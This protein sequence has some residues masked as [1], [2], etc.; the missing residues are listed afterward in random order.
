MLCKKLLISCVVS[1]LILGANEADKEYQVN[2]TNGAGGS[3]KKPSFSPNFTEGNN[4]TWNQSDGSLVI[5]PF[6]HQ[7]YVSPSVIAPIVTATFTSD[8]DNYGILTLKTFSFTNAPFG[9]EKP[10]D[11]TKDD[12]EKNQLTSS[13]LI[14]KN[15]ATGFKGFVLGGSGASGGDVNLFSGAH[16][17]IEGFTQTTLQGTIN[18]SAGGISKSQSS[19]G[20]L[21]SSLSVN[22]DKD[23]ST[24]AIK[25]TLNLITDNG[26]DRTKERAQA[27]FDAKVKGNISVEGYVSVANQAKIG[28]EAGNALKIS[29]TLSIS[30]QEMRKITRDSLGNESVLDADRM[31]QT[32]LT[33]YAP[34]IELNGGIDVG[35]NAKSIETREKK[36]ENGTKITE[37]TQ[38]P[39]DIGA[40]AEITADIKA[41]QTSSGTKPQDWEE[42]TKAQ[43]LQTSGGR[44]SIGKNSEVRIKTI[45]N[46]PTDTKKI[47]DDKNPYAIT[48]S[49]VTIQDQEQGNK[50]L[51]L[52]V[53]ALLRSTIQQEANKTGEKT[54]EEIAE[55]A[56]KILFQG[57]FDLGKNA[58]AKIQAYDGFD[59]HKDSGF[60]LAKNS[61]LWLS[62][63][64]RDISITN[65]G[66]IEAKGGAFVLGEAYKGRG[67]IKTE[68]KNTGSI[69]ISD[70]KRSTSDDTPIHP[71]PPKSDPKQKEDKP[72]KELDPAGLFLLG[73]QNTLD[74][75]G[76]L[77]FDGFGNLTTLTSR[78]DQTTRD[79]EIK[80]SS[81]KKGVID[82]RGSGNSIVS[83]GNLKLSSQDIAIKSKTVEEGKEDQ[84]KTV[85]YEGEFILRS[86]SQSPSSLIT[87]GSET[88]ASGRDRVSVT[89][90]TLRIQ[91]I[92]AGVDSYNLRLV[93][94]TLDLSKLSVQEKNGQTVWGGGAFVNKRN[95]ELGGNVKIHVANNQ[96]AFA[97][98]EYQGKVTQFKSDLPIMKVRGD[99]SITYLG[100]S[101]QSKDRFS[102]DNNANLRLSSNATFYVGGDFNNNGTTIFSADQFGIGSILVSGD[103]IFDMTNHQGGDKTVN[104]L[105]AITHTNFYSL[106]LDRYYVL[107]QS[108]GQIKYRVGSAVIDPDDTPGPKPRSTT[109]NEEKED[110]LTYAKQQEYLKKEIENFINGVDAYEGNENKL[111]I[112]LKGLALVDTNKVAFAVVRSD[113]ISQITTDGSPTGMIDQYFDVLAKSDGQISINKTQEMI[114]AISASNPTAL[115][116]LN[117]AL[118]SKNIFELEVLKDIGS[119]NVPALIKT[120]NSIDQSMQAVANLQKPLIEDFQKMQIVR[121]IAVQNRMMRFS[122]PYVAEIELAH[123]IQKLAKNRYAQA[124]QAQASDVSNPL[125]P[126]YNPQEVD[127]LS[128]RHNIWASAISSTTKEAHNTSALYGMSA[129]YE[130]MPISN[131]LLGVYAAYG[132]SDFKSSILKN[133][134]H[135]IDATI[136]TRLYYENSEVDITFSYMQAFNDARVEGDDARLHQKFQFKSNAF[137]FNLKYGY[138]IKIPKVKG[139]FVKPQG[140]YTV[141]GINIPNLAGTSSAPI[142]LDQQFKGGMLFNLGAEIRQYVSA[143]SFL[144][145]LPS[146][147]YNLVKEEQAGVHFAGVQNKIAYTPE[148]QAKGLFSI[149]AGGEGYIS[150]DFSMNLSAG[151]KAG[152]D[153][154]EHNVSISAGFKYKF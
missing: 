110:T 152:L 112:F 17:G 82:V 91:S 41:K 67:Q 129:G 134:A 135:N 27:S 83:G 16:L 86:T 106:S 2:F 47:F 95:L 9:S 97:N 58:N 139:L 7:Y 123:Y 3:Y 11:P 90:G 149:Y 153:K 119:Y 137:D 102:F 127:G 128:Y 107:F 15:G 74:N 56:G 89:G 116:V 146:F 12:A 93:D 132:Y 23:Y 10:Q 49:Y 14:I 5:K 66:K 98:G 43:F 78:N 75:Q 63:G 26:L 104:P 13:R 25:S 32:N 105:I 39:S 154:E 59:L 115:Q 40:I 96:G 30:A 38:L 53:Q 71:Q 60:S 57:K 4:F 114:S 50:L 150:P 141:Y 133:N 1:T 80:N 36:L 85:T 122:N 144:Y 46:K 117:N 109:G 6:A 70:S 29:S 88:L 68:L 35:L 42:T 101:S 48:L 131:V 73:Q 111:G 100:D 61:L 138:I 52:D 142:L 87:F 136:Y 108:R 18:V 94:T 54:K 130:Y 76:T 148:G 92:H 20:Y 55:G 28:L 120:A 140:S 124:E 37:I 65:E 45:N 103:L 22:S 126:S 118:E 81:G 44:I 64:T 77:I 99:N 84:K 121:E 113:A 21:G 143:Y 33:L 125:A 31:K 62:T 72:Q 51:N 151:Y 69:L 145:I 19:Y 79:L 147:E 8:K 34:K 24:L